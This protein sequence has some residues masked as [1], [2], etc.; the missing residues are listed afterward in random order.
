MTSSKP[1]TLIDR[2]PTAAVVAFA[3]ALVV[4]TSLDREVER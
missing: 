1:N 2:W 4:I 3:G